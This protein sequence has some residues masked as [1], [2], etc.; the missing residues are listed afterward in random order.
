MHVRERDQILDWLKHTLSRVCLAL[1][2]TNGRTIDGINVEA[3]IVA[4][5]FGSTMKK[6]NQAKQILY[7]EST[8]SL[9]IFT[10]E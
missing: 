5:V 6:Y 1:S 9:L 10:L 7:S 2:E 3:D 4:G 8:A